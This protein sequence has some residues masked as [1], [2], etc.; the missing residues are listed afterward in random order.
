M[1]KMNGYILLGFETVRELEDEVVKMM[2]HHFV[3]SGSPVIT[4]L[5]NGNVHYY[6]A[7][8]RYEKVESILGLG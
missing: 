8:V 2:K 6:Q 5:Q 7:M 3:V 1:D 4:V